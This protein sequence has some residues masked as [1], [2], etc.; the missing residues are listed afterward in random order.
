MVDRDNS[1]QLS[2]NITGHM[3][4]W[5]SKTK[6]GHLPA[7]LGWITYKFKLWPGIKY[8][9]ATLGMPLE[10]TQKVLQCKNFHLL[11][12]LGVNWN[13]KREWRTLHRAFGGIG[14]YSL[15]IEHTIAMINMIIQHYSTETT[16]AKKFLA[17]IEAS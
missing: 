17:F 1:V 9:L 4:K 5:I 6:N 10:I 13:L 3:N 16:L 8:G 12:F 7:R 11:S 15:P 14:L 2:Q